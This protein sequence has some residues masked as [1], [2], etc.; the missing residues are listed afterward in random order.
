M[1]FFRLPKLQFIYTYRLAV[2]RTFTHPIIHISTPLLLFMISLEISIQTRSA[3]EI[4][5]SF[6]FYL[7]WRKPFQFQSKIKDNVIK[8]FF[9]LIMTKKHI[10]HFV[11]KSEE[12]EHL[13]AFLCTINY[14]RHFWRKKIVSRW[15]LSFLEKKI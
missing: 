2:W 14:Q 7:A 1:L 9:E 8:H 3:Y 6:P 4:V 12:Y 13:N 5:N 15:I 10:Q 11:W